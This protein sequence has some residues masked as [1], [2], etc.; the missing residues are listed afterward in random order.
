MIFTVNS[1]P[2]G[3]EWE[4]QVGISYEDQSL[5]KLKHNDFGE[6][7]LTEKVRDKI[8]SLPT[9]LHYKYLSV[10]R[11]IRLKGKNILICLDREKSSFIKY[12]KYECVIFEK[13]LNH[14]PKNISEILQ[15]SLL[16]LYRMNSGYGKPISEL[17]K[18]YDFFAKDESELVYILNV[19]KNKNLIDHGFKLGTGNHVYTG[20]GVL[21]EE[22]G[23]IE[24]EESEKPKNSKQVFVAMW[25]D[26]KMNAA[27][28]EIQKACSE[29]DFIGFKISNKEHNKEI[30][31]EI[32]YEIKRSHFLIADVTGQRNGV[33]FE[34]G[35]T[36]GLGIP[37]IWSC[38]VDEIEKVHF[39]TR[40]YNHI[41]WEDEKDLF[42]KLKNRIKGT[43]L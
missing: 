6:L 14:F 35:Y 39:D 40:Q 32:L 26:P 24:I 20:S 19:L 17:G 37:V 15:R 25:F 1:N 28:E 8:E 7:L 3:I 41:V 10:L 16:N 33:Y 2:L 12:P 22:K 21:I 36:M 31:G 34:A 4:P 9:E 30:S 13:I 27:F 5:F 23:W 42:E 43:I 18:Y 38:K 29:Y 11:E